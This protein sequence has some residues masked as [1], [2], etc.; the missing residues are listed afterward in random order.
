MLYTIVGL[1]DIFYDKNKIVDNAVRSTNPYDYIRQGCY[2]D[3]PDV[4]GGCNRVS[5]NCDFSGIVSGD[6][7]NF[8]DK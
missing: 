3:L 1:D 8:A 2:L 5:V 6:M 7:Q 4:N